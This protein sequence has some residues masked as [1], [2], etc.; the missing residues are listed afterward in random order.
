MKFFKTQYSVVDK[1][2]LVQAQWV[3]DSGRGGGKALQVK[4]LLDD[5]VLPNKE[6]SGLEGLH[7]VQ[8]PR[9][10]M[11]A[12]CAQHYSWERLKVMVPQS[13][14]SATKSRVPCPQHDGV[15]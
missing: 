6:P 14:R 9:W 3:L 1:E 13:L 2:F 12:L 15:F 4:H 8:G 7:L 10:C 5:P 11:H